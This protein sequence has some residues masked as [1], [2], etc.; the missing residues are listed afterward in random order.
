MDVLKYSLPKEFELLHLP[1]PKALIQVSSK[2]KV[3][4][5]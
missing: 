1:L 4:I 3:S 2:S 5:I